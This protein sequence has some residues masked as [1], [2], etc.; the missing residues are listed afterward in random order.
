ML[1]FTE[2]YHEILLH[3]IDILYERKYLK[4]EE[5]VSMKN[6]IIAEQRR[7]DG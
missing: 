1:D 5:R 2:L 4:E 3:I 7:K 6:R